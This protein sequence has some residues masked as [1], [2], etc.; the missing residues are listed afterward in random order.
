MWGPS[1][2]CFL[3]NQLLLF[4]EVLVRVERSVQLTTQSC[5]HKNY[6]PRL[7]KIPLSFWRDPQHLLVPE[8]CLAEK[9]VRTVRVEGGI[10]DE[11]R[12]EGEGN[13]K[14][15]EKREE[16]G[17]KGGRKGKEK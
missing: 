8:R 13:E 4:L 5:E 17:D 14:R 2:Y 12:E 6:P 10:K 1:P 3:W 7:M 16:G 15:E 11:A 9:R